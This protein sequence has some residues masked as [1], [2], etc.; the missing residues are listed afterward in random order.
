MGVGVE[1]VQQG[2]FRVEIHERGCLFADN[3][4]NHRHARSEERGSLAEV[5][6][7]LL[8]SYLRKLCHLRF[9]SADDNASVAAVSVIG[10][11][12]VRDEHRTVMRIP[13]SIVCSAPRPGKTKPIMSSAQETSV[14]PGGLSQQKSM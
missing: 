4:L 2:L 14:V 9:V 13:F 3:L 6:H 10:T 11:G 8:P 12:V 5:F 7:G 1:F